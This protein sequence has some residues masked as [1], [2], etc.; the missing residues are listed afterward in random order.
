M[1]SLIVILFLFVCFLKFVS[2]DFISEWYVSGSVF[3]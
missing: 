1:I 3:V 2:F